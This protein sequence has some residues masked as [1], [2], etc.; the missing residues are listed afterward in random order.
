MTVGLELGVEG[1]DAFQ[2]YIC[3]TLG[4]HKETGEGHT[5]SSSFQLFSGQVFGIAFHINVFA[6]RQP[7]NSLSFLLER[8]LEQSDVLFE[9]SA[10]PSASPGLPLK[11]SYSLLHFFS[12]NVPGIAVSLMSMPFCLEKSHDTYR[13]C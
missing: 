6:F 3:E 12:F 4:D 5:F 7:F 10:N 2:V 11:A 1:A 9:G 8:N 13:P